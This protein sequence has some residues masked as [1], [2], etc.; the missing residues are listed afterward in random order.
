MWEDYIERDDLKTCTEEDLKKEEQKVGVVLP[1]ALKTL[2]KEHG[3]QSPDNLV[4]IYPNG[5]RMTIDCIYHAYADDEDDGYTISFKTSCLADDDYN[6]Y[7]VFSN[8]GNVFLALDYNVREVDPP[9]VFIFR[10]SLPDDPDHQY[11]LADN[12]QDFLDK[13]TV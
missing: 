3:G 2:I 13:Y 7:V 11:L 6:N 4:P 12:F 1:D 10:D 8:K 9:V 5:K